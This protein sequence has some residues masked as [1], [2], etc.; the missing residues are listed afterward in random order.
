MSQSERDLTPLFQKHFPPTEFSARRARV[1][2]WI[3]SEACAL[4]QGAGPVERSEPFRQTNEF[5]YLCGVE[6]PRAL[7]FLDGRTRETTLFLPHRNDR[8]EKSEGPALSAEDAVAIRQLTGVDEVEA[9]EDLEARLMDVTAL[10]TPYS[11]AE[12]P[13]MYRDE[14]LWSARLIAE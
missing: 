12:G 7:L 8:Q 4:V 6:T 2:D 11:P 14:L 10:Y 13:A 1:F 5:Y 9:I 3:G